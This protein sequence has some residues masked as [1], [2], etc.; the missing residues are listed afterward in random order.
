MRS[1]FLENAIVLHL[2]SVFGG[3]ESHLPVKITSYVQRVSVLCSSRG[4]DTVFQM[5]HAPKIAQ[6]LST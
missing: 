6:W 3:V 2:T 5:S 1:H 4:E